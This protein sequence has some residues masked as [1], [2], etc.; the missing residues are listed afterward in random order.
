MKSFIKK[1]I[2][3]FAYALQGASFL[4][5]SEPHARF[6][7][8]VSL[9]VAALGFY[10]DL[11]RLEWCLLIIAVMAVFVTEVLNTAI[12]VLADAVSPGYNPLVGRAKD[13]AAAAVLFAA[14]GAVFI[15]LLIFGGHIP[16][17]F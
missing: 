13:V 6:H 7:I 16:A 2:M 3:S 5:R 14:V 15:G 17:L 1:Q 10:C 11:S 12:E 4:I 9:A 8:A